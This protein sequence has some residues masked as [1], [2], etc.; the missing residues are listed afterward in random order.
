MKCYW[1]VVSRQPSTSLYMNGAV[2]LA[3]Q[4][5]KTWIAEEEYEE[6]LARAGHASV[7]RSM[8]SSTR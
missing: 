7:A 6:A 8:I 1:R 4:H 5:R 3:A 2:K